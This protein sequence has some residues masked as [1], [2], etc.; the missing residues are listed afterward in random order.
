MS[1]KK[2]EIIPIDKINVLN[3][4]VRNQKMFQEIVANIEKVGLKRPITVTPCKSGAVGKDYD[5]ICGQGRM[6]G[7]IALGQTEI[8]AVV[9]DA[10][11]AQAYIKSLVENL[12]RRKHKPTELMEGIEILRKQGYDGTAIAQKTGLTQEY[13]D[14]IINLL[15]NG[16]ERLVAAV[17][18]GHMPISIAIR[19]ADTSEDEQIALQEIY[20]TS[21]LRGKKFLK[22]KSVLDTR[23]RRGKS[24]AEQ[25]LRKQGAPRKVSA[26]SIVLSYKKEIERKQV[27]VADARRVKEWLMFSKHALHD[28]MQDREY[29]RLLRAEDMPDLPLPMQE[30]IAKKGGKHD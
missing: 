13:I 5:L 3:P 30:Y 16:E 27:L 19:I 20:E 10:T 18:S 11:Q 26:K 15:E 25:R 4:R 8:P 17:E 7:F 6:E 28:L 9:I 21:E 22:L 14:G 1:R 24:I 2:I 29:E 23:R 12:A